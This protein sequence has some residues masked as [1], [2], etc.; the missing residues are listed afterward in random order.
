M[1]RG[2]FRVGRGGCWWERGGVDDIARGGTCVICYVD[3]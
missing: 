2:V 3:K 1:C